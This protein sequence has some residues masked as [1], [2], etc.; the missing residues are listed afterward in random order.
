MFWAFASKND[1]VE[2]LRSS[3][4]EREATDERLLFPMFKAT[5]E[6]LDS[7]MSPRSTS[8]VESGKCSSG[9][10]S[11]TGLGVSV[12]GVSKSPKGVTEDVKVSPGRGVELLDV[13]LGVRD[14]ISRVMSDLSSLASRL[15][16]PEPKANE[17][18][19]ACERQPTWAQ[20]LNGRTEFGIEPF[21]IRHLGQVSKRCRDLDV[22]HH[23]Q[24]W[25]WKRARFRVEPRPGRFRSDS[26]PDR[27]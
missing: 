9:L 21:G 17:K 16:P 26:I 25:V 23:E 6:N 8:T 3:E 14:R 7:S 10:P 19:N 24:P 13:G 11:S 27:L 18:R 4:S 2:L 5:V 22:Y 20:S 12:D 1:A 15:S